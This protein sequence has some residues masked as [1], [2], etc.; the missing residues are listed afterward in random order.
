MGQLGH[1]HVVKIFLQFDESL[2]SYPNYAGDMLLHIAVSKSSKRMTKFLIQ[3]AGHTI[4]SKNIQ[5]QTPLH[6][7]AIKGSLHLVRLLV[8]NGAQIN[9]KD[10]ANKNPIFYAYQKNYEDVVEFLATYNVNLEEIS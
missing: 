10:N 5:G 8:K 6:Y 9:S 1:F 3:K 7:A 2:A 4:N